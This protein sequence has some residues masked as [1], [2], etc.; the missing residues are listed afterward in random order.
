MKVAV[1]VT[2]HNYGR[3]LDQCIRSVLDQTLRDFKVIVVDDGSTDDT[4]QVVARYAGDSRLSV[5]R[6]HGVGL[7][8]AANEGIMRATAEYVMR[9]DADDYLDRHALAVLA[10]YLDDH[11]AAAMV[12][13]DYFTV[14]EDGI[15]LGYTRTL[16]FSRSVAGTGRS[17]LPGGSMWRRACLEALGGFDETLRYQEDYDLWLRLV[18]RY[19]VG[20]VHLPLLYYRQHARSMSRNLVSRSAARRHVKRVHAGRVANRSAWSGLIAVPT[21]WPGESA[22]AQA[23]LTEPFGDATLLDFSLGQIR[24]QAS[25]RDRIIVIGAEEAL[26]RACAEREIAC[27]PWPEP[28]TGVPGWPPVLAFMRALV[29]ANGA[30]HDYV[31]LLSPYCP[32]RDHGRLEEA[33]NTLALH[34]CDVV[35][36]VDAEAARVWTEGEGGLRPGM[37]YGTGAGSGRVV[38]EAG[39]MMVA[40]TD[41]LVEGRPLDRCRVGYVELLG[42]EL[43]T[44]KDELSAGMIADLLGGGLRKRL[45]PGPFLRTPG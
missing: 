37:G 42:P 22:R 35:L 43:L 8:A 44:V 41:V 33:V 39:E 31:A 29:L 38:R 24:A 5:H 9:L 6:L 17:P 36:S 28:D 26:S 30:K 11:P 15:L 4:A 2:A 23:W 10:G 3:F 25:G 40:R 34:Q 18:G 16:D 20:T 32:F 14:R 21:D 19:E 45:M 13:P 27:A 12:Y 1:V 7:A